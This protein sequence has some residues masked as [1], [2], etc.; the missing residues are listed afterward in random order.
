MAVSVT[1]L[2]GVYLDNRDIYKPLLEHEPVA[3]IG[4]SIY[5]YDLSGKNKQLQ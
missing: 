2:L 3:K 4:Y 1:N 5:V